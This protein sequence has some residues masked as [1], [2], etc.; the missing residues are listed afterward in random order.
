MAF[1]DLISN[2]ALP[3]E[4]PVRIGACA[5]VLKSSLQDLGNEKMHFT[6]CEVSCASNQ[7]CQEPP[8]IMAENQCL[9]VGE[10]LDPFAKVIAADCDGAEIQIAK[11]DGV[12]DNGNPSMEGMYTVTYEEPLPKTA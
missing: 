4:I 10:L 6:A 12:F 7:L 1:G 3:V 11:M 5:I 8:V 2:Q 9:E